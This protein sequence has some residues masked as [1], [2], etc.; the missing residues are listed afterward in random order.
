M[1]NETKVKKLTV[2]EEEFLDELYGDKTDRI[3]E[4][5]NLSGLYGDPRFNIG[6]EFVLRNNNEKEVV[7]ELKNI[8]GKS[9]SVK[10]K[11]NV[12]FLFK[13]DDDLDLL[14]LNN[15]L[16]KFKIKEVKDRTIKLSALT[17]QGVELPKEEKEEN[18]RSDKRRI[19]REEVK[20]EK[21]Y[22][23]RTRKI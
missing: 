10:C 1:E 19:K 2:D 13:E 12:S 5:N 22:K 4:V 8:K 14:S 3:S 15:K 18:S 23:K 11:N 21:L 20:M 6:Q 16:V 17:Y 9:I 7:F